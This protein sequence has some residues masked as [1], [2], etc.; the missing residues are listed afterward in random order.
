MLSSLLMHKLNLCLLNWI[1]NI[2]E[3]VREIDGPKKLSAFPKTGSYFYFDFLHPRFDEV[4]DI[5]RAALYF[6]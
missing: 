6:N 4:S 3:T 5:E 2:I 1:K